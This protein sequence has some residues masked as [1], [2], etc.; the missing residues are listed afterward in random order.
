MGSRDDGNFKE[1]DD[2]KS[3]KSGNEHE[4]QHQRV[5]EEY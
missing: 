3:S 5:K 2:S 1:E 4:Y